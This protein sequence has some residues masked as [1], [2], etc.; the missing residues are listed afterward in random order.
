MVTILKTSIKKIRKMDNRFTNSF[1]F[2]T[3]RASDI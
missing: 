3:L 2:D 1:I